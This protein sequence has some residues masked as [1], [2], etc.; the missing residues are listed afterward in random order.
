MKKL[1]ALILILAIIEAQEKYTNLSWNGFMAVPA[2][3]PDLEKEG[4]IYFYSHIISRIIIFF[5]NFLQNP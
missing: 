4:V 2:T 5:K 3:V 1:T